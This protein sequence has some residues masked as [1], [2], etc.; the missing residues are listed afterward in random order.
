MGKILD[1]VQ[2]FP[3]TNSIA[4]HYFYRLKGE[5]SVPMTPRGW[6][7][8]SREGDDAP[9]SLS[10]SV[11]RPSNSNLRKSRKRILSQ[12]MV[13]DIDPNKV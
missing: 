4:S 9:R 6:F 12:T 10:S 7:R 11:A 5:Y 1:H 3:L 2:G 13:I 8:P